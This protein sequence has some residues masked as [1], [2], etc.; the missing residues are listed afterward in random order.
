[1]GLGLSVGAYA[2]QAWRDNKVVVVLVY[3]GKHMMHEVVRYFPVVWIGADN[4]EYGT[5]GVV[6]KFVFGVRA[7]KRIVAYIKADQRGDYSEYGSQ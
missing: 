5:E 2:H 4:V 1:M 3:V 6:Y 7:V